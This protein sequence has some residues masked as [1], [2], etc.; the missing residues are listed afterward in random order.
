MHIFHV[1]QK[2]SV[3]LDM[4]VKSVVDVAFTIVRKGK[5]QF[6]ELVHFPANNFGRE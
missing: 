3:F 5:V 2:K 6:Q 4:F 1:D